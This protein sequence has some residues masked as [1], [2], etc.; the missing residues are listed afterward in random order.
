MNKCSACRYM[1]II[2]RL[3]LKS[4]LSYRL[5]VPKRLVLDTVIMKCRFM[6][7][8]APNPYPTVGSGLLAHLLVR[9]S[10]RGS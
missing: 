6:G 2:L 9:L 1:R 10:D 5:H 7:A 4:R 3:G 8:L